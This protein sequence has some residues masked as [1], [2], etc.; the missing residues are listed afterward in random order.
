MKQTSKYQRCV[1]CGC[2]AIIDSDRFCM[3]CQMTARLERELEEKKTKVVQ[4]TDSVLSSWS[5]DDGYIHFD[6]P[7]ILRPKN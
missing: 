3:G 1:E 2:K 5:S 7:A 4:A 6:H